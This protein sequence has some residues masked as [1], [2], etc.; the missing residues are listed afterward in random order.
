MHMQ[1]T[2]TIPRSI[3]SSPSLQYLVRVAC[4]FVYLLLLTK[5]SC[6]VST[7]PHFPCVSLGHARGCGVARSAA[8]HMRMRMHMRATCCSLHAQRTRRAGVWGA[9]GGA[10]CAAPLAGWLAGGGGGGGAASW[11]HPCLVFA[12]GGCGQ[13]RQTLHALCVCVC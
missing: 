3:L 1:L 10:T 9:A 12:G 11:A 5:T 7:Q 2:G 13:H 6:W 4:R 8:L